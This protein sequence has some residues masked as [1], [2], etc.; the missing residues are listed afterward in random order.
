VP[1]DDDVVLALAPTARIDGRIALHGLPAP[2]FEVKVKRRAGNDRSDEG[3]AGVIRP[4][5]SFAIAGAPRG[6][7]GVQ[8]MIH[9]GLR[10][11]LS[12]RNV[13][14]RQP[15][16]RV[17]LEFPHT[18]RTLHVITRN[19]MNV[20]HSHS[21]AFVM[22]GTHHELDGSK[23]DKID[24]QIVAALALEGDTTRLPAD[25]VKR[26]DAMTNV[27]TFEVVPD[28]P[29]SA[30]AVALPARAT[31]F[32]SEHLYDVLDN[33]KLQCTPIGT[34]DKIVVVDIK[35]LPRID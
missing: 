31:D 14:I 3:T 33:L 23:L 12:S 18:P 6:L 34:D 19:T 7:V 28:G 21:L 11:R 4:D 17:E 1:I 30:C 5:G 2:R 26:L 16:A 13:E 32:A 25:V 8:A 22:T 10:M 9:D 15:V 24:G 35:P 29:I 27:A 20:A